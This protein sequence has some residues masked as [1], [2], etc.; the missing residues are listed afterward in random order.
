MGDSLLLTKPTVAL[1]TRED[2]PWI[3]RTLLNVDLQVTKQQTTMI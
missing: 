3:W 1:N 2:A